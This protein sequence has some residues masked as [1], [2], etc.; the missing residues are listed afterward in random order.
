[1]S[2]T[3]GGGGGGDIPAK[4]MYRF[5]AIIEPKIDRLIAPSSAGCSS[6]GIQTTLLAGRPGFSSRYGQEWE[7]FSSPLCPNRFWAHPASYPMGIGD[8]CFEGKAGGT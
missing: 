4:S 5:P 3:L 6:V 1:M 8:A 2:E 7:F